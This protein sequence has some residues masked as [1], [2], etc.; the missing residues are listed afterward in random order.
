MWR[1]G[2]DRLVATCSTGTPPSAPRAISA[3]FGGA[4]TQ[5]WKLPIC[6]RRRVIVTPGRL[7]GFRN[8]RSPRRTSSARTLIAL[9]RSRLYSENA[10][11]APP[12]GCANCRRTGLRLVRQ[13]VGG[14][15]QQ[16]PAAARF[17][18]DLRDPDLCAGRLAVEFGLL[19]QKVPHDRNVADDLHR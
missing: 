14:A 3:S 19:N 4:G 17:V 12:P 15:R 1:S 10:P 5:R 6:S 18:P 13:P 9:A 7:V 11:T 8:Q 16:L 2:R